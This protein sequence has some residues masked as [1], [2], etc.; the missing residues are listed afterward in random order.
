MHNINLQ[1]KFAAQELSNV[2][3]CGWTPY[4]VQEQMPPTF[5]G[6]PQ[7]MIPLRI[8]INY[9]RSLHHMSG[10]D[11]ISPLVSIAL[12][13]KQTQAGGSEELCLIALGAKHPK[14]VRL[15]ASK[16]SLLFLC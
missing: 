3:S 10:N 13:A 12:G 8:R 15:V 16:G 6:H 2:Q 14:P 11:M 7:L 1:C 5:Q 9:I 4:I